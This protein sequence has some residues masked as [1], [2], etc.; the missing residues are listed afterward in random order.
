MQQPALK[1]VTLVNYPLL[2]VVLLCALL[3]FHLIVI[4][5]NAARYDFSLSMSV[6]NLNVGRISFITRDRARGRFIYY[7]ALVIHFLTKFGAAPSLV[8]ALIGKIQI[9]SN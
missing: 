8:F 3:S 2:N 5:I 4:N 7:R 1:I 9:E 6:N